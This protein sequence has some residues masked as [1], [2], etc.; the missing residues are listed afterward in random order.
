MHLIRISDTASNIASHK[1]IFFGHLYAN[2]IFLHQHYTVDGCYWELEIRKT[3]SDQIFFKK[4]K[5]LKTT[6]FLI[7]ILISNNYYQYKN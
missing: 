3:F 5:N 6:K 1:I 7:L 4:L 2:Y